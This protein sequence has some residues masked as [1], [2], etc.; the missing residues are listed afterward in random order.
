[1][2]SQNKKEILGGIA[3]LAKKRLKPHDYDLFSVLEGAD[4][5]ENYFISAAIEYLNLDKKFKK[6]YLEGRDEQSKRYREAFDKMYRKDVKQSAYGA[7]YMKRGK[8][9]LIL[10]IDGTW[11]YKDGTK[12]KEGKGNISKIFKA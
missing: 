7:I 1:M 9:R 4:G 6:K 5:T 2:T 8:E 12:S 3:Y 11:T 10:R